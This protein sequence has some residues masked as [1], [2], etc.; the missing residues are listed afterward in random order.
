VLQSISAV[1]DIALIALSGPTQIAPEGR[2]SLKG[3]A[4]APVLQTGVA[5]GRQEQGE[6]P[7]CGNVSIVEV[8]HQSQQQQ[9]LGSDT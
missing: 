8:G 2:P 3:A 4:Q 9:A 5:G 6:D 1:T 7:R